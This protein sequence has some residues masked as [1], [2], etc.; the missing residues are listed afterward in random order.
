MKKVRCVFFRHGETDWNKEDRFQ[1]HTDIGLNE[2]G[3]FQAQTLSRSFPQWSG[4][5]VLCS[6]L[7]RTRQTLENAKGSHELPVHISEE[8][9]EIHLGEAEGMLRKD[10]IIKFGEQAHKFWTSTDPRD[11]DFG[12]PGG[13]TKRQHLDRMNSYIQSQLLKN[14]AWQ[15]V[16]VSTHGGSIRRMISA[17]K[18]GEDHKLSI[19]HCSFHFLEFDRESKEWSFL[20]SF[21]FKGEKLI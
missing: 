20:N 10:I 12:Y 5:A 6:D 14:E 18:G 21:N 19:T 13:E 17:A 7:L 16:I 9:R 8:L 11:L 15:T 1:G 4:Q 2:N 3:F